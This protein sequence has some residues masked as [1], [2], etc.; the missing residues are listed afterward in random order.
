MNLKVSA[1]AT[2]ISTLPRQ[3]RADVDDVPP[4]A[5]LF[6]EKLLM[7]DIAE[8]AG[9]SRWL[10]R[11]GQGGRGGQRPM[12]G[13]RYSNIGQMMNWRTD[14]F[15]RLA[16]PRFPTPDELYEVGKKLKAKAIHWFELGHGLATITGWLYPLLWPMAG[17]RSN[18]MGDRGDRC[19]RDDVRSIFARNSSAH[20]AR[21]CAL[22]D[23]ATLRPGSPS[24]SF[25]HE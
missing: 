9:Q 2:R 15:A 21:R 24:R 14:W 23:V 4:P 1:S 13:D 18:P 22:T 3:G 17:A 12:E 11:R 19:G 8:E 5:F 7:W 6:D 10:V 16:S 20:D 25:V